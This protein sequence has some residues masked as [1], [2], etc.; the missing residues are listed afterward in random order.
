LPYLTQAGEHAL[1]TR[2]YH[3]ARQFGLQAVSLLGRLP[4]PPQHGERV[5]ISLQLVQAYAFSG[6]LARA[7]EILAEAEHLAIA[8]GDEARLGR[9]YHRAAQIAWLSGRPEAAGSYAHRALRSAEALNDPALRRA[10]L[11]MQ[12]RVGIAIS[13]FD[14]AI[15]DLLR[16]VTLE[17]DTPPPP[18]L[19]I[20][21]GYL[22][23][24]YSHVGS[25][26]RAFDIARQSIALAHKMAAS[27]SAAEQ[28]I[29]FTQMQ[30][31]FVLASYRDWAACLEALEAAPALPDF[32]RQNSLPTQ[33]AAVDLAAITPLGFMSL[34]LKGLALAHTG[35]AERAILTIRPALAWAEQS[36]YRV[37]HYLPRT[38]L[39]DA[40]LQAGDVT[41]AQA[42]AE[43]ALKQARSAGNR[44][45]ASTILRLL[46][47][48]LTHHPAPN[49][50]EIESHL[51]QSMH[52]FRQVRARPDL[53]RTYLALRRLYDRAGQI[54]W[55][56]DCH[57]RA[58][59]IF[60][61]LEMPDEL[62]QAQGQAGRAGAARWSSLACPA[63][64][65]HCGR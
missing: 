37:F 9:L 20:V 29:A 2:S 40:L 22:G 48:V 1:Q 55:A 6:D 51:I 30:L 33:P 57:F 12:G 39:A 49:W 21:M 64:P 4:G 14:D 13:T 62:R 24:A 5:D 53:A 10:A 63:R 7:Q 34:G 35:Q 25:W 61:E 44:W 50:S 27:G 58:T 18:D 52:I 11:R 32:A 15:A 47:E 28:T 23:V 60:E 65:Q 16:Y 36:D 46:A 38:Y 17:D 8:L 3:A 43:Q 26:P 19:P 56:V 59:S 41:A 31:A 42:E 54:A 45:A